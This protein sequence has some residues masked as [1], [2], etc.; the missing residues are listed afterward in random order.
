MQR[1]PDSLP[2][3]F[4]LLRLLLYAPTAALLFSLPPLGNGYGMPAR[5]LLLHPVSP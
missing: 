2:C 3:V 1:K 5:M 4:L